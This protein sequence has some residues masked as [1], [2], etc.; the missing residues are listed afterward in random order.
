MLRIRLTRRG[1]KNAPAYRIVVAD[2]KAKRDGKFVEIIGNYNPTEDAKKIEYK[3]DR[4]EY[5]TSTGALPSTAVSKLIKGTYE[6]KKY[7]PKAE[8][9]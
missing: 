1:R 5:W 9:E 7:D 4:Y 6:Y 8:K 2:Q 3:K